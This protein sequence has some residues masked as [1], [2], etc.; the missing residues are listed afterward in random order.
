MSGVISLGLFHS[1][2]GHKFIGA[3]EGSFGCP[4]CGLH[5][6][7]HH[8]IGM[9]ELPVQIDDFGTGKWIE[10]IRAAGKYAVNV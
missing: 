8:L 10:I 2:C 5:D 3:V 1:K 9:E 6:G 7:D 4:V